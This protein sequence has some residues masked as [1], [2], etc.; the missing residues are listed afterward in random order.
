MVSPPLT[1]SSNLFFFRSGTM[2]TDADMGNICTPEGFKPPMH[3]C[4]DMDARLGSW[5]LTNMSHSGW[6]HPK[7]VIHTR[8]AAKGSLLTIADY[9]FVLLVPPALALKPQC[10]HSGQHMLSG[11]NRLP[12]GSQS[13]LIGTFGYF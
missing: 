3:F 1:M 10:R 8:L 11:I 12:L 6:F 5:L 13:N 4:F 7:R 9:H 2:D